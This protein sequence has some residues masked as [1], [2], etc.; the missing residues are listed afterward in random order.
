MTKPFKHSVE[1]NEG[2]E[3]GYGYDSFKK[4]WMAWV[5]FQGYLVNEM[6]FDSVEQ[7]RGLFDVWLNEYR[8]I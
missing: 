5:I 7:A 4:S 8:Q 6:F 1:T 2:F 3:V